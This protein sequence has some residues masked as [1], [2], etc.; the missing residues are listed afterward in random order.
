MG[1]VTMLRAMGGAQSMD[2]RH[3]ITYLERKT[4]ERKYTHRAAAN[5]MYRAEFEAR[6]TLRR[7]GDRFQVADIRAALLDI[8]ALDT[9]HRD[10]V[11]RPDISPRTAY[12]YVQWLKRKRL[13]YRDGNVWRKTNGL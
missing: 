2:Q 9:R 11:N 6:R 13:I 1:T 5:R 7:V 10:P 12:N 8:G 4:L 3:S